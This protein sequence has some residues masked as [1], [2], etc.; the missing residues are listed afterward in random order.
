MD[1]PATTTRKT[2]D[3]CVS[4]SELTP[5]TRGRICSHAPTSAIPDRLKE[6][7]FVPGT[8]LEIVRRAPLGDP[9]ELELRGYRLCLRRAEL[10]TLCAVPDPPIV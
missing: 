4:V 2:A 8:V 9:V 7:G 5:G 3:A 10:A 1:G 6:L